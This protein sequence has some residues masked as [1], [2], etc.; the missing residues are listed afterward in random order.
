[1]T[2]NLFIFK[3]KLLPPLSVPIGVITLTV[4]IRVIS[5]EIVKITVLPQTL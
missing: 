2:K 5:S 4:P 3:L 1:M